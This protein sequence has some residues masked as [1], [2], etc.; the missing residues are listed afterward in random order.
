MRAT[1]CYYTTLYLSVD[2]C[3]ESCSAGSGLSDTAV[4]YQGSL[5]PVFVPSTIT[6]ISQAANQGVWVW[7]SEEEYQCLRKVHLESID[8][9]RKLDIGFC[10]NT[11]CVVGKHNSLCKDCMI[12]TG[13]GIRQVILCFP[14]NTG[15]YDFKQCFL[16]LC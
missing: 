1:H 14:V 4:G 7:M 6:T 11:I 16:E 15:L 10:V 8:Q 2:A 5:L 12:M 9:L 3:T 13:E